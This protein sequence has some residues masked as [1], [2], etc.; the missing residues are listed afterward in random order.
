MDTEKI[1]RFLAEGERAGV[2]YALETPR[3]APQ[4]L[5]GGTLSQRA[6]SSLEFR[7][8]RDYQPGDDLR[9]IDWNVYARSDQLT[10]KL[11]REEVSPHLDVLL[12]SSRSMT[13]EG[14]AKGQ[15]T[16]ALAAFFATAARNSGFSHAVWQLG[17]EVGPVGN[18]NG[19]PLSWEGITFE[20]RGGPGGIAKAAHSW[21]SRGVRV[22]L[23]D[24]L[25]EGDPLMTLRPLAERASSLVVLQVL[26]EVDAHPPE[27]NSLRMVDSE[28]DMVREIYVDAIA[29]RRYRDALARHQENW[30]SACRQAGAVFATVIAEDVLREWNFDMLVA[31]G[32]LKIV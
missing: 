11:F 31:A 8:H 1:R 27:G 32:V 26:A 6:G 28:T 17:G 4:G 3:Q 15:A 25:W 10:I 21:K 7:D 5:S 24:L 2:R 14:T 19:M 9:H 22:F 12:D 23:S 20:H 18:G 16:L 13:L 29:V 30:H